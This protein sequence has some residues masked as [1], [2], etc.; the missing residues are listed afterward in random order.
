MTTTPEYKKAWRERNLDRLREYQRQY[1]QRP[2]VRERRKVSL[3]NGHLRRKFGI[4]IEEF[5]SMLQD[6]GSRCKACGGNA[7]M[8]YGFHVDH[9]HS[10]GRIRGILCHGCNTALGLV[11]ESPDRL[12]KLADYLELN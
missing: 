6:Q 8:G 1:R 10:T 12:R 4:T 11:R 2:D 9:C 5:H 7:D 3:R